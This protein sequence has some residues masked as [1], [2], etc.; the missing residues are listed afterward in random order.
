MNNKEYLISIKNEN[1]KKLNEF[2]KIIGFLSEMETKLEKKA[3]KNNK[4]INET[5]H[6]FE[7]LIADYKIICK[8][9]T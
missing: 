3:K 1:E 5:K 8:N 2:V 7:N 9:L 4:C 6:L